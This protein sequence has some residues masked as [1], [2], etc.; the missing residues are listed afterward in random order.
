MLQGHQKYEYEDGL[1][2]KTTYYSPEDVC[3]RFTLYE[4]DDSYKLSKES[5][6][7]PNGILRGYKVYSHDET[8]KVISQQWYDAEG[9]LETS[10]ENQ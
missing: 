6:Y 4:Y 7:E 5:Y 9:N 1:L 8:G 3:W 10:M 2:S